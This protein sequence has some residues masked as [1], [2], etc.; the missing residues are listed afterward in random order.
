MHVSKLRTTP[1]NSNSVHC[2]LRHV[3]SHAIMIPSIIVMRM[4]SCYLLYQLVRVVVV[5]VHVQTISQSVLV[6]AMIR[7]RIVVSIV[8]TTPL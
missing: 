3:V 2:I 5:V 7:L 4:I 6:N 1:T 8:V